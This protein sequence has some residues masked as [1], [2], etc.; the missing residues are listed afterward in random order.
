MKRWHINDTQ[1]HIAPKALKETTVTLVPKTSVLVVVRGMILAHNLPVGIT[2]NEVTIN[3]DMK[4][5]LQTEI[6]LQNILDI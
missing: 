1:D 2:M 4:A 3:Q 5:L 6:Y